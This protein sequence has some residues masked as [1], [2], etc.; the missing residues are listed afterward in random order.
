MDGCQL[1]ARVGQQPRHTLVTVA[2]EIDI[3]TVPRPACRGPL[4]PPAAAGRPGSACCPPQR[5]RTRLPRR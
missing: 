4:T 5:A 1:L 2:G 3:V